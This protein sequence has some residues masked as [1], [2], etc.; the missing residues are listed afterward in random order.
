M[1]NT[2]DPDSVSPPGETITELM[3]DNRMS[4]SAFCVKHDIGPQYMAKV[5]VGQEPLTPELIEALCSEFDT[6]NVFWIARDRR[7]WE[8]KNANP[9]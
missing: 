9:R 6:S 2:Y 4:F 1:T 8:W 7:Y 5:L 3:L